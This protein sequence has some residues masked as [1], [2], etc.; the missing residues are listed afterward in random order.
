MN[1][2]D[3]ISEFFILLALLFIIALPL[4]MVSHFKIPVV[5]QPATEIQK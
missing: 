3:T 4:L 2:K 5:Y 1:V